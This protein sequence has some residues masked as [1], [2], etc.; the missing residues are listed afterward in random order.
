MEEYIAS[1][2]VVYILQII[3]FVFGLY[4]LG[5]YDQIN[6]EIIAFIDL[7]LSAIFLSLM[8]ICICISGALLIK[9]F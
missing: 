8:P 7:I 3:S 5:K 6:S 1:W 4:L 9:P 2:I